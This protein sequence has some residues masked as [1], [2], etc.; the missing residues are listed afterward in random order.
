MAKSDHIYRF[1]SSSWDYLPKKERDR[2]AEVWT[3][4][5]QIF[6]DVYQRFVELDQTLNINT[7]PVYLTSRWNKYSFSSSNELSLPAVFTAYQDISLGLNLSEVY[8]IALSINNGP[9]VEIDCR[10]RNP[11]STKISEIIFKINQT[12]G[13]IF[14]SGVFENTII[15][16]TTGL[17]GPT[18]RISIFMPS[19]AL[20]N[21]SE[22]IFGLASSELP[23]VTP[24]LPY[25]YS[26]P[27]PLIR[28]VPSLQDSIRN[29]VLE[30]YIISGPDFEVNWREGRFEF[31]E[32][33]PEVL[34]A[35]VTHINEEMP[36][37]NFGYLIDYRDDTLEPQDYLQNLQGLWFAFWQGPRPEFIRRALCLLFSLPVAVDD[38]VVLNEKSGV[39]EILHIDGQ[40]RSYY[41][42]SQ[43]QWEVSVGA[44]VEKFEPLVNGIDIYDKTN[45][46]GFVQTEIGRDALS[47]FA[48]PGAT[49]GTAADTDESK[50]VLALEEHTF[51]PQ[52]NVNAFVRPDVNIGTI[53]KFLSAIRPLHKQFYFQVI[54]AIFGEGLDIQDKVGLSINLDV[55][56]NLDINQANWADVATRW[57][58]ESQ[59]YT[60][61]DLDSDTLY[62]AERGSL[63]FSNIFGS[64]PQYDVVFD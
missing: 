29:E 24:R 57:A 59:N 47:P 49:K 19:D 61:L 45:L 39:M 12:V 33:P 41:L 32:K 62:F 44:Y 18:A 25:R 55:T 34:W 64:M 5:E 20:K 48:L 13:F 46:P 63:E 8:L 10:G 40:I 31:K 56:P 51:L 42:P 21:A 23:L 30:Y 2:F 1:L 22:L 38:G 54:V 6:A 17:K 9:V 3:G 14:A 16:L 7:I 28:K 36:Y 15:R 37:Y 4:Y 50:A 60:S 35:K 27:D 11:A 58:Y 53:F 52:I 43:L 26:L